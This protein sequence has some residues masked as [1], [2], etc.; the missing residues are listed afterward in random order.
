VGDVDREG[1]EVA[2]ECA[3]ERDLSFRDGSPPGR[4]LAAEGQVVERD[5]L[6]V[7]TEYSRINLAFPLTRDQPRLPGR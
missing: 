2:R 3:K 6:Q 7:G 4:P 1:G 5:R